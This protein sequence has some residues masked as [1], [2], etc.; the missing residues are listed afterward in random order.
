MQSRVSE[1]A[2]SARHEVSALVGLFLIATRAVIRVVC[3][4]S[5]LVPDRARG[6]V[7]EG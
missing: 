5:A 4:G 6:D 7:S 2:A 1:G 3:G